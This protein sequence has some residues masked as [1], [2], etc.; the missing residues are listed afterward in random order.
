MEHVDTDADT[1]GT[2]VLIIEDDPTQAE[3]L[4]CYLRRAGLRVDATVSGSLAIHTV[5]QLRPRVA[6]IDYNLPDLDGVTVAERIKRL[7][8]GTAM[9]VMSGRIDWLSDLTLAKFGI[10]TFVNK[11]V[12]LRPL[13]STVRKLVRATSRTGLPPLPPRKPLFSL[14]FGLSRN[15]I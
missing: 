12:A 7:S 2:D 3:E 11:P 4:A 6:L 8:P 1:F 13:C 10:F 9:I 5:A 14:P 15:T